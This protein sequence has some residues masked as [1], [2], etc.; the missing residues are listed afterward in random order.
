[1]GALTGALG[2]VAT[3]QTAHNASLDERAVNAINR[4][5]RELKHSERVNAVVALLYADASV[6]TDTG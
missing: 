6:A 2:S 4:V 3:P 5:A 1:M